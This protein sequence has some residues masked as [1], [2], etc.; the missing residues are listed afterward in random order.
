MVNQ[1]SKRIEWLDNVKAL[2]IF[3]VVLGHT[4][5]LPE[6]WEKLIF[7]FHMPL[8]FFLSG[9]LVKESIKEQEFFVYVVSKAKRRLIPYFFFAIISYVC[10]FLLFRHFG[11]QAEMAISP[12]RAWLG[13]FVGNGIHNWLPFNVVLWFFLCLFLA[14]ILF[15]GLLQLPSQAFFFGGLMCLA[16]IGYLD[17][18]IN[19]PDSFRLPWNFDIALTAVVFIGIGSSL[20]NW[21]F[22]IG[23]K[24]Q[25]AWLLAGVS[26]CMYVA[27]SLLNRKV[28][29][30]A[31]VYGNFFLF[32]LAAVSGILFWMA[33]SMLLPPFKILQRVGSST[34]VIFPLHLLVFPFLTGILV[35][36]LKLPS[37]IKEGSVLLS[38]AFAI[39]SIGVLLP[40]AGLIYR[41]CPYILGL[42]AQSRSNGALEETR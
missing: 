26:V 4:I 2:A 21:I 19:P 8:F 31:G 13:I 7:S 5:G 37:E 28:A 1:Q 24:K 3:F 22:C 29:F 12:L 27:C 20:R 18:W 30:V 9:L 6:S 35:Y 38:F 39:V 41:Y 23:E 34:L 36:I 40:L 17:T 14:E 16:G 11:G 25:R 33:F 10:W 15:F 32:Y 42:P